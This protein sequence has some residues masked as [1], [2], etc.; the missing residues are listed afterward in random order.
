MVRKEQDVIIH[1]AVVIAMGLLSAL[2]L[3][4]FKANTLFVSFKDLIF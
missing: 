1:V 4:N 3:C 2:Y